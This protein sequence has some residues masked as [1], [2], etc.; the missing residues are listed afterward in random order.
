MAEPLKLAVAG[1]GGR[2]GRMLIKAVLA[3]PGCQLAAAF[4]QPGAD[5]QGTD[6]GTLAGMAPVGV[7]VG[8]DVKEALDLADGLL[9]FT[10]PEASVA[11]AAD[12]GARNAVHIVGTTGFTAPE[13]T[14]LKQNAEGARMVKAG[15]FSL[16]VNLLCALTKAVA[17]RLGP[18][19]DIEINEIHHRHKVDAPSGTALMLGRAAA[20]AR[21]IDLAKHAVRA[22][23]GVTGP[24]EKGAIGFSSVR[25]G[26]VI[27]EHTVIFGGL[28][29]RLE[30]KHIASDRALFAGGAVTAAVW[31]KGQ[32]PGLYSMLDV[33]GL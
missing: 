30:F 8:S 10:A 3:H 16:G 20:D 26:E 23:D 28:A 13:E 6:A 27:G 31:A 12:T 33:L 17:E 4:D 22:R 24:R 1:A 2:M 11:F 15:N 21:G 25:A 7:A 14:H 19:Y 32:P 9:D 5:V 29:E 18:D